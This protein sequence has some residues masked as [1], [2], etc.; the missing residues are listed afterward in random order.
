M[1]KF[2]LMIL[3]ITAF[4]AINVNAAAFLVNTTADTQDASP[5]NGVCADSGGMCSLRAAITEA[6]ALAGADTINLLAGTYTQTLT[7]SENNNTGGDWDINSDITINGA[8]PLTT[9]VQANAA[10]G[11]ATERVFHVRFVVAGMIVNING[12]TIRNGRNSGNV[13][14]AGVRLDAGAGTLNMD[15]VVVRDNRNASSGGGISMSA[16]TGSTLNITNSTIT[17]NIAGSNTAGTSGTGGGIHINN[18]PAMVNISN[19]TISNNTAQSGI[20][21]GLGGGISCNGTVDIVDSTIS[22]NMAT[23]SVNSSFGGGL[24][25]P[26]GTTT[27]TNTTISNNTSTSTAGP[28]FFGFAGAVYNQN[29][30]LVLIAANVVA[31]VCLAHTIRTLASTANASTTVRNSTVSGNTAPGEG[32]AVANIVGST[33]NATTTIENSTINNNTTSGGT[34]VGGGALNFSGGTGTATTNCLNSTISGN[35]AGGGGGNI[36]NQRAMG[37]ANFNLNFCT[38]AN[39]TAPV[40]GGINNPDGVVNLKNSIVAGSANTLGGIIVSQNYNLVETI[41]GGVF[42]AMPNDIIG[43]NPQLGPLQNNG[44]N[45]QTHFLSLTSPAVDQIPFKINGCDTINFDQRRFDRPDLSDNL[46]CD[47]GSVEINSRPPFNRDLDFNGD[48]KTDFGVTRDVGLSPSGATN[49]LRWFLNNNGSTITNAFDWGVATDKVVPADYDGDGRTDIA[50]W[51]PVSSG[52]PLGNAY[53]YIFSSQLQTLRFEDFGQTG[54]DP[55]VTG[56]FDGD[57]KADPAVYREGVGTGAQSRFFFRGSNNN[58]AGNITYVPWGINGDKPVPGDFDG[59]GK[60]D[61]A[62]LRN[63]G[64]PT[65]YI[66]QST[67]GITYAGFGLGTDKSVPADYDGD[68]RTDLAVIRNSGGNIEWFVSSSLSGEMLFKGFFGTASSDV[69]TYGDYDGDGKTDLAIW[70]PGEFWVQLS[71]NGNVITVPFG[72]SGDYPI[73]N[74]EIGGF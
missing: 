66:N 11:V 55:L 56:D 39:G 18:S 13:F 16:A 63:N 14:G 19:S 44:G 4:F 1:R 33:F 64:S 8:D 57:G 60:D 27:V 32:A 23:S 43:L 29:S 20:T 12:V 61:F 74:R 24:Y 6:N 41:T 73:A 65:Y 36:H 40:G 26:S 45:T 21:F 10:P 49:Q 2:T 42:D 35:S 7:G 37:A 30:I 17:E 71:S 34:A 28:A 15:N 46:R 9:I 54:D 58:P 68:G 70:R 50:V 67:E 38:V 31:N 52:E 25:I 5:G 3:V 59:D 51:R 72:A 69:P 48:G 22:G 62:V 47:M 53:L